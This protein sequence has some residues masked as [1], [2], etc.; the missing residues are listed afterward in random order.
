MHPWQWLFLCH[1]RE[2]A[3]L[4]NATVASE[5]A[6][7]SHVRRNSSSR[8][9]T[10]LTQ[11]WCSSVSTAVNHSL[12][13]IKTFQLPHHL[14]TTQRQRSTYWRYQ[15]TPCSPKK[16]Q[17][18]HWMFTSGKRQF[19]TPRSSQQSQFIHYSNGSCSPF[20]ITHQRSLLGFYISRMWV[21]FV[22][23][24]TAVLRQLL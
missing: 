24:G 6:S 17:N 1:S 11:P 10:K 21:V 8:Q 23:F 14:A 2:G 16:H 12:V 7:H 22:I 18:C 5:Q 13:G 19:S 9:P 4:E 20:L 15:L 3:H